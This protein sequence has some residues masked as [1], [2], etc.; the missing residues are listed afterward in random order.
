M[1]FHSRRLSL[2]T[3]APIEIID[4]TAEVQA[5]FARESIRAGT[6]TLHSPHTTA[7]VSLNERETM[8]QQDMLEFLTR[9]APKGAGYGHDRA[10]VDGR[11]NAH[12]HLIGLF[13]NASESI[14]VDNG[15]LLL[16]RWQSIFFVELDGPREART[17]NIQISGVR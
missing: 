17:L 5:T 14:P 13:M 1:H 8:L 9:L 11:E 16:G 10:P 15:E 3:T 4:I 6:V 7:F 12:A 2:R